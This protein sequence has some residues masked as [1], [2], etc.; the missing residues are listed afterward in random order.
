VFK[1][2]FDEEIGGSPDD[3]NN[4]KEQQRF[5]GHQV[6]VV[7]EKAWSWKEKGI[8]NGLFEGLFSKIAT[9]LR[10]F[11]RAEPFLRSHY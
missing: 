5:S 3:A 9:T 4:E 1:G 11:S 6:S 7:Q 10:H 2:D 8:C